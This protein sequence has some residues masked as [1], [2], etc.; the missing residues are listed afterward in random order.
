MK[1][2]YSITNVSEFESET[3]ADTLASKVKRFNE[4]SRRMIVDG[5]QS[6]NMLPRI[7]FLY[8]KQTGISIDKVKQAVQ[9]METEYLDRVVVDYY[10]EGG[11]WL[12]EFF[13]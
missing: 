11:A 6:E 7:I 13:K 8:D 2:R 3:S 5:A 4:S 1:Y 9:G 10:D 12:R